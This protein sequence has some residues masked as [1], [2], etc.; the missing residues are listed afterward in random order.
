MPKHLT[1]KIDTLGKGKETCYKATIK[2]LNDS[3]ILAD[4]MEDLFS[5]IQSTMETFE[6]FIPKKLHQ[7]A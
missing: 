6:E 1:I 4:S 5:A 2:E 3:I 7:T